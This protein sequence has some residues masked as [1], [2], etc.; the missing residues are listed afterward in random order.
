MDRFTGHLLLKFL[1]RGRGQQFY[2]LLSALNNKLS[3]D[4]TEIHSV[5][6]MN[7]LD[8]LSEHRLFPDVLAL[9]Q[10][11]TPQ[12]LCLAG[13]PAFLQPHRWSTLDFHTDVLTLAPR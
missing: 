5:E 11:A 1:L 2:T 9:L 6:P 7:V 12:S 8:F 4:H 3:Y 13:M 10:K